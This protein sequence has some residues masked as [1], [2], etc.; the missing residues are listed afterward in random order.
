MISLARLSHL[1]SSVWIAVFCLGSTLLAESPVAG[2]YAA[3]SQ[4][5]PALQLAERS[6]PL[7][8]GAAPQLGPAQPNEHPMMPAL[9]WAYAGLGNIEKIEDYSSTLV[10]HERM[11]DGKMKDYEYCFIKVRHRPFSVYMRFLA[12]ADVKGREVIYIEGRNNGNM[13]AHGSG[14][15][16]KLFGTVSLKPNGPVAMKDQRYP[17]TELGILNLTRRLVEVAEKDRHYGECEVRFY[18]NAKVNNRVCTIIEAKH[19]VP[20]GNFIFHVARIYVDDELNLPIR[21]EAYNWPKEPG[22]PPELTEEYTYQ[23]LKLNNG[24][25][26]A[27]FDTNNPN[28]R[29]R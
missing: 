7:L 27:D 1:G 18:K 10:K 14:V 20:R 2:P 16:K 8:K 26:D 5:R 13:W 21:Y 25:T 4:T 29:F 6:E 23:N 15:Q 9:R 3:A 22:G 11:Y 24:F 17:I 19:P 28:Y 12:P